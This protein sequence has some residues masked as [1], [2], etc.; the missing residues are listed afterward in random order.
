MAKAMKK[1]TKKAMPKM[2]AAPMAPDT[3][4]DGYKKGGMVKG[5][6]K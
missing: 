5:K 1:S 3:D 6:K 4:A 2:A